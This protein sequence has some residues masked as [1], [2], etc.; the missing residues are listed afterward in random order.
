VSQK[1]Q[2]RAALYL[3]LAFV[4]GAV[5]GTSATYYYAQ[6]PT[7]SA[8]TTQRMTS[9]ELRH[10]YMSE[11]RE[12]LKLSP[13]QEKHVTDILDQTRELF[14]QVQDKHRPEFR[15]IQDHQIGLIRAQ[16]DPKQQAEYEKLRA[17][18]QERA[19]REVREAPGG[20]R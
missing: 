7:T 2:F 13:E 10:A 12:R 20:P 8:A 6:T 14:R 4:A 5:L 16:L 9:D 1:T 17:E 3:G 11:M 18:R 19:K 15:A